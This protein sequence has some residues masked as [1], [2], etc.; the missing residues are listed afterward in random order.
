MEKGIK[1]KIKE[2]LES[3]FERTIKDLNFLEPR[4]RVRFYSK[5]LEYVL[6]KEKAQDEQ[7]QKYHILNVTLAD[8]DPNRKPITCESQIVDL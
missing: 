1:G 7:E 4:E 2:Y 8:P 3:N 6:A 5:M